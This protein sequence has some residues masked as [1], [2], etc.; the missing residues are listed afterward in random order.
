MRRP[1]REDSI[2]DKGVEGG[3]D[4]RQLY[5]MLRLSFSKEIGICEIDPRVCQVTFNC[6]DRAGS[7][8]EVH[9]AA[10]AQRGPLQ[11]PHRKDRTL[12]PQA[13]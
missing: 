9:A 10:G 6:F 8:H 1:P 4:R 5:V 13:G 12:R 3:D 11:S 2:S 7:C